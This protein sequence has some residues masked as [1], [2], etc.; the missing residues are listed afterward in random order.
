MTAPTDLVLQA[1]NITSLRS[2]NKKRLPD[3]RQTVL[4][5]EYALKFTK[6]YAR[7]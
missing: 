3:G 1:D 7:R 2:A 6:Q 5:Y 4:Y